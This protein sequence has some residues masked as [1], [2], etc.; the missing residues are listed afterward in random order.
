MNDGALVIFHI[1]A[2]AVQASCF[3][4]IAMSSIWPWALVSILG[5]VLSAHQL[6]TLAHD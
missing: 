6:W 5:F 4:I 2:M 3:V 1:I